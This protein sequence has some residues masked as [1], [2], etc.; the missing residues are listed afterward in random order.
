MEK[1]FSVL[2]GK[3]IILILLQFVTHA[4][5]A[6]EEAS[7]PSTPDRIRRSSAESYEAILAKVKTTDSGVDYKEFRLAYADSAGYKPNANP[8][9]RNAMF[10]ALSAKDHAQA[11]ELA[12]SI[13][14][15]RYVDIYGAK[16]SIHG[17][18]A[19]ELMRSIV[20]SG[21][22]STPESAMM[23]ISEEEEAII[24]QALQLKVL[25][26]DLM[27]ENGHTYDKVET[28]DSNDVSMTL[29]FNLDVPVIKVRQALAT[30]PK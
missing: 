24:L 10:A 4:A 26:Q 25:R 27:A 8:E 11:I 6:Q 28:M 12:E 16:S 30:A 3:I 13:L 19:R 1:S 5:C 2:A 21:D 20:E 15:D 17:A 23:L 14:K 29:Y 18:L 9:I 22:G 7:A